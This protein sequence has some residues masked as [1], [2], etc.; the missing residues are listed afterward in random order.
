MR[1]MVYGVLRFINFAHSDIFMVGAFIAYFVG[2][3]VPQGTVLGGLAALAAAAGRL[4]D[5]GILIERFAYRPLRGGPTLNV[6]I[7]AIGV[8]LFL[9]YT[10]QLVF[11]A[12]PR[13]FPAIFPSKVISVRGLIVSMNQ[14]MVIVVASVLMIA[15][16]IA[17]YRTKIGMAMRAVSLNPKAALARSDEHR[18]GDLL[19]LRA[20]LGACG[21]GRGPLRPQLSFHRSADGG[22]PQPGRR[23]AV[24]RNRTFQAP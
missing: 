12:T 14:V 3:H 24:A 7:T 13:A 17:V 19:H 20:R 10:G 1:T 18:R 23:R 8:S 2:E 16:Q 22:R 5:R 11:S 4:R 6:L 21:G 9:E 15:L